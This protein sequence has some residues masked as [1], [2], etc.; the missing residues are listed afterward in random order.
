MKKTLHI[1]DNNSWAGCMKLAMYYNAPK[2]SYEI[3]S[4]DY[5]FCTACLPQNLSR[6]ELER[7]LE[8]SHTTLYNDIVLG[9]A[10]IDLKAYDKIVVWHTY[11][12]NSLLLLYFFST[13]V[14]GDLYHCVIEGEDESMKTGSAIPEDIKEGV[15]KIQLLSE[16]ERTMFNKIY[17]SLASTE[18]IPKIADGY[19]IKCKSKEFVKSL[20]MKHVTK[21]PQPFMRIVGE[22]INLFPKE[23]L[24]DSM[25]LDCLILEMIEDGSLKPLR[26]K[27]DNTYRQYPIGGFYNRAYMY[28]GEDMRE[29]YGFSIVK[30]EG[31]YDEDR[32]IDLNNLPK[33]DAMDG[34]LH[35]GETL[36]DKDGNEVLHLC[37][38]LP[39]DM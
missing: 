23:Y 25:Y 36:Y 7:C 38:R 11:D 17:A 33:E 5:S 27:R 21:T 12:S 15:K 14:E 29:W 34:P 26:I 20:L 3:K 2:D 1:G 4:F 6:N 39:N 37:K 8:G 30:N 10:D 31:K 24:F 16:K 32:T 35:V 9:F 19:Q 28:K 22:T 18:G 13:I